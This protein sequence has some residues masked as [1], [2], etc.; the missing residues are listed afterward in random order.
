MKGEMFYLNN[1]ATTIFKKNMQNALMSNFE[2]IKNVGR[3]Y[4]GGGEAY[5]DKTN[6]SK[7]YQF[8]ANIVSIE[9]NFGNLPIKEILKRY[10]I[11]QEKNLV[12]HKSNEKCY[13]SQSNMTV[14]DFSE[15]RN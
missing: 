11:E 9:R 5:M 14:V 2:I 10:I 15:R 3:S 12:L 8:G 4:N 13:N 7:K 1:I 6:N